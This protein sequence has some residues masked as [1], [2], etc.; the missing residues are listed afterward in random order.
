MSRKPVFGLTYGPPKV[1]KTLAMIRAFPTGLFFSLKGAMSCASWLDIDV[2]Y[3]ELKSVDLMIKAI[4]KVGNKYPAIIIDDASLQ[5]E[6]EFD[7]IKQVMATRLR[8]LRQERGLSQEDLADL[9]GCHRTYVGM[10]ERQQGNPSL[11]VLAALA[12]GLG[13]SLNEILR[14]KTE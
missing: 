14:P 10:I 7:R 12:A 5:F 1:G 2:K 4:Q 3:V 11:A 13:V 9:A 6:A 8:E